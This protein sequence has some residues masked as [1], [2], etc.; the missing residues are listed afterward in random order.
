[1]SRQAPVPALTADTGCDPPKQT[2]ADEDALTK[3]F[4]MALMT[5]S[6]CALQ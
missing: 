4:C 6:T 2:G 5:V 1:M 3:F